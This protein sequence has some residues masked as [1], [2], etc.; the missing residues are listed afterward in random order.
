QCKGRSWECT[1]QKCA[2]L[3]TA[4]GDP[5]YIT[6]DGK[7]FSFMGECNYLLTEEISGAFAVT[8]ENVPCGTNGITCTKSVNVD[9]GSVKI[10]LLRYKEVTVNGVEITLPKKYNTIEIARAGLFVVITTEIG[11]TVIWDG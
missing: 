1:T 5:H 8:A 3:C 4:T 7:Q 10:H 6:F 2:G 9:I 11:L